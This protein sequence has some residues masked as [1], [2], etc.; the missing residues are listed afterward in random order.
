MMEI[1]VKICGLTNLDDARFVAQCGADLLGF[2]FY[3]PSPRYVS[4]ERVQEIVA[5]LKTEFDTLPK[6]VGIF[7]NA[8]QAQVEE[9]LARCDLDLAQ[10]HG[11]EPP[12][13]I[14]QFE[15]RAFK[16][17]N[18]RS[19]REAEWLAAQYLAG[20]APFL[21]LDAY[22]PTLRGGTGHTADWSMAAQV[23]RNC[24][25][26]LAGGL[27]PENVA[28]AIDQVQP[29]GVDV[30]SGVEAAKGKKDHVKVKAFIEAVRSKE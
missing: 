23:A 13:F 22:H 17:C 14:V 4:P 19:L 25:L 6:F 2:V 15:G 1:R 24:L 20:D 8:T 12:E 27:N 28:G 10:L 9:T 7:V 11:D 29:W 18:P 16:A 3:E 30:S 21:L 26:L 5:D